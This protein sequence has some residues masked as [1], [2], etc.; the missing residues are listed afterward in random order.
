MIRERILNPPE[1]DPAIPPI[2][3]IKRTRT[4]KTGIHSPVIVTGNPVVDSAE[5]ATKRE[6][7][8]FS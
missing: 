8:K 4:V 6:E 7:R 1:T 3:V 2:A 5:A